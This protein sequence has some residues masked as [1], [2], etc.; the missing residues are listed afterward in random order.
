MMINEKMSEK[1]D[2]LAA[3]IG[4]TPMLEISLLYKGGILQL[5]RQHQGPGRLPHPPPGL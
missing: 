1:F 3:L 2:G 5:F 4:H